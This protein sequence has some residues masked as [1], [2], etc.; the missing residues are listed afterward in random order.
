[1]RLGTVLKTL[2]VT[3]AAGVVGTLLA[4]AMPAVMPTH[5]AVANSSS[6]VTAR[7]AVNIRTGAGTQHARMGVLYP[8]QS[9]QVR[10]SATGGW[11]P[12]TYQGRQGWVATEYVRGGGGSSASPAPSSPAPTT[13][14][15]PTPS[16]AGTARTTANLNVRTGPGLSNRIL[17]TLPRGTSVTRTGQISADWTQIKHGNGTAWVSSRYLNASSTSTPKPVAPTPT[18]APEAK[19]TPVPAPEAVGSRW[20]TVRLNLWT[21]ATGSGVVEV[22]PTG[23]EFKITGKV[24]N[25][26]AEVVWKGVSR[27]VTAGYLATK[28]PQAAPGVGTTGTCV[29][30]YYNTGAIT[31]NGE[32]YD[33]MGITSAH[34]TLPFNSQVRVTNNA[35]GKSVVVRINDRGPFIGD[36]CLDLSQGAFQA[37]SPISAG[38]LN[39]TYEVLN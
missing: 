30:S 31:A 6:S 1:M 35:N 25:G 8:G 13:P 12:V 20:G 9:L 22:A 33:P 34:R 29:A 7:V 15:A 5:D 17:T 10:G 28:A 37:I 38:I 21:G 32:R 23:T 36:R 2:R 3:A 24:S 4:T 14:V 39:V 11:T 26:R 16:E 19:P 18:P 27:W